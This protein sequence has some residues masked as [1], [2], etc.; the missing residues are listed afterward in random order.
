MGNVEE[1]VKK[2]FEE[3]EREVPGIKGMVLATLDG[4]PIVSDVASVE[5]KNRLA[6]M[7]SALAALAR[8]MGPELNVGDFEGISVDFSGGR[9]FCYTIKDTAIFAI[10]T[11][12]DIN[13]GM[14]NLVVPSA[15][16]KISNI[17]SSGGGHERERIN[18]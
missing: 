1:L 7:V 14:L 18:D 11:L 2:V 3:V 6:A 16:E 9:I 12:K 17:I 4:L 5:Q 15:L 10:A 13:L 8:R